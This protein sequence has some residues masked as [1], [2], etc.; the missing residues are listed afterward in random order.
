MAIEI[1]K[2]IKLAPL[3]TFKI[4]G[5]AEFF[6]QVKTEKELE[7]AISW[8]QQ[9]NKP[10]F[11]LAGGSNVLVN[12]NGVAALVI[13]PINRKLVIKG[14][15]MEIGAGCLLAKAVNVAACRGLSGLEWAIGIPGTVGGAVVGNAGAFGSSMAD[16]VET[17]LVYNSE[18]K[19][20][21]IFSRAD[22]GFF[23]RMSIFKKNKNLIVWRTILKLKR[24]DNNQI[25]LQQEKYLITRHNRQP[26]LPSAGSVFKNITLADLKKVNPILA[27]DAEK[28]KIAK[29]GMVSAGWLIQQLGL[30]GKVIGGAKVS[31]EHA[32]FIVNT[33]RAT[34]V[35]VVMLISY[36]KQQVRDK[37][38]LQL[39][40]EIEYL[41]F[42]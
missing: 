24:G 11:I 36:I 34:A 3:T 17:V 15:R 25:K 21:K 42:Y 14:E 12:D 28:K 37:I 29:N 35:D 41:G 18:E 39:Q 4:G 5:V 1:K 20:F 10:Y 33:G 13:Q 30:A 22:C 32:N 9:E 26:S 19:K 7:E 2:E 23:Y 8:A 6:C 16:K 27:Q 38:G 31:L 40:E